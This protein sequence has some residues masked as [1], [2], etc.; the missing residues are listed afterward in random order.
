MNTWWE[1]AFSGFGVAVL[2]AIT[3]IVYRRYFKKNES[4]PVLDE[5]NSVTQTIVDSN[6]AGPVAGRDVNIGGDLHINSG[7]EIQEQ[8][9]EHPTPQEMH[10]DII[11]VPMYSHGKIAESFAGL[12]VKWT[13]AAHSVRSLPGGIIDFVIDF[14][15]IVCMKVRE[16]DYPILRTIRGDGSEI[17]TVKGT[18]DYVQSNGPVHLK[19]V[20]L[21]FHPQKD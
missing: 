20:K 19:D 3:T 7:A 2:T 8:Y 11:A 12:K 1:V 9:F 4:I 5:R 15:N 10:K 16:K 14:E 13:G 18:I 6:V 17:V 21:F